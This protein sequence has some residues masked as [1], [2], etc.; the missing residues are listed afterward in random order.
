MP[1]TESIAIG[2]GGWTGGVNGLYFTSSSNVGITANVRL[3]R[4]TDTGTRTIGLRSG[5]ILP[6]KCRYVFHNASPGNTLYGVF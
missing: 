2:T 5:I 1:Y 6:L 4:D 3:W